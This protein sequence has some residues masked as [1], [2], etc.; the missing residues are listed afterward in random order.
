MASS[1]DVEDLALFRDLSRG[2]VREIVKAGQR[3]T[4]PQGWSLIAEKTPGDAA[5]LLLDGRVAVFL[6]GTKVAELGRGDIVGEIALRA[7]RLRTA[8]VSAMTALELL[9]FGA[10]EFADLTERFP[11][12]R[13]AIDANT[14]QRL[15]STDS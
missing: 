2:N 8:T 6:D 3:V 11:A 7:K 15:Q 13:Q 10:E 5:Y 4:V 1:G 12:F 9:R 14:E